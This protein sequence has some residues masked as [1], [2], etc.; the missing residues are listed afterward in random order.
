MRTFKQR[1]DQ[2]ASELERAVRMGDTRG[3]VRML[4]DWSLSREARR[5]VARRLDER[6][7]LPVD[8][9]PVLHR[10]GKFDHARL[11]RLGEVARR[12][13]RTG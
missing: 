10:H 8:Q 13:T 5:A 2:H 12:R 7:D 1:V 3:A 6:L 11:V 4:D 9:D